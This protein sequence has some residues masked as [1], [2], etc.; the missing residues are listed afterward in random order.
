MRALLWLVRIYAYWIIAWV[1]L[2][3]IPG[4]AG[5]PFHQLLGLPVVPL[6]SLFGFL[7]IGMVGLQAVVPLFLLFWL[8]GWLARRIQEQELAGPARPLP[9]DASPADGPPD[10]SA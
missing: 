6:L 4:V 2:T 5:S 7:H 9:C 8:E 1:L 10:A 3:W